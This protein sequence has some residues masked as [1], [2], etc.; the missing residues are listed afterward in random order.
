MRSLLGFLFAL[1][2]SA[3]GGTGEPGRCPP[4][5]EHW[6]NLHDGMPE[7]LLMTTIRLDAEGQIHWNGKV[8]DRATLDAD[9]LQLEG[10][11]PPPFVVLRADRGVPCHD[12]LAFHR[13]LDTKPLCRD[14]GLCG[15]ELRGE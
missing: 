3:C 14:K 15:E 7:H 13:Y 1:A 9:L 8:V 12:V 10:L 4:P 5:P 11:R 6:L 2:I